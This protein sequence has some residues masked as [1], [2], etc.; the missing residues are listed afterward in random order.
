M[1]F[2][3]L[4]LASKMSGQSPAIIHRYQN[5]PLSDTAYVYVEGRYKHKSDK[6]LAEIWQVDLQTGER[7]YSLCP[8]KEIKTL[9]KTGEIIKM[10]RST[11]Q[12]IN[13]KNK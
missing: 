9:P 12:F 10:S 1:L 5:M 11:M 3:S 6:L 2:L 8:R 4:W 7:W 13:P